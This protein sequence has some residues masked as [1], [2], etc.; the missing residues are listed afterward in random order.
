M[1]APSSPI[2]LTTKYAADPV[3]QDVKKYIE[4]NRKMELMRQ[5]A[6]MFQKK[7]KQSWRVY[8]TIKDEL[9][10]HEGN[11]RFL[12]F[13]DECIQTDATQEV[14]ENARKRRCSKN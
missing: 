3:I 7:A 8:Y 14:T 13:A 9:S 4:L 11:C 2:D 10:R 6:E 5:E 1:S 12:N